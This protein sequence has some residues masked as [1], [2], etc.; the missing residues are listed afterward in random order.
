M[1]AD[2]MGDGPDHAYVALFLSSDEARFVTGTEIV[3]GGGMVAR[4]D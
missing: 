4:C 3:V 2:F 1:P